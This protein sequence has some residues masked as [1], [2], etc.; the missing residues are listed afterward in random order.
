MMFIIVAYDRRINKKD[1]N[2]FDILSEPSGNCLTFDSKGEALE[3]LY[4]IRRETDWNDVY[5]EQSNIE[6]NRLH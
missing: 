4:D 2:S 5:I 6:I 1:I 3:F